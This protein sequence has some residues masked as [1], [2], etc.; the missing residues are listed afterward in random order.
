MS[1]L[2]PTRFSLC[3]C[4]SEAL[5]SLGG[6]MECS[7][8]QPGVMPAGPRQLLVHTAHMTATLGNFYGEPV[9]LQVL[10][11]R[12]TAGAYWRKI[13]LFPRRSNRIVEFGIV[14]LYLQYIPKVACDEILSRR[15]PLGAVLI[16]HNVHRR[17][18]PRWYIKAPRREVVDCFGTPAEG[19]PEEIYG[20]IG[21]IFCNGEPA[22]ELLE[23]VTE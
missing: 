3:K 19:L 8:V 5:A 21:T 22:I 7:E 16:K 18:E 1:L 11:D 20:R 10:E 2:T 4:P 14:R 9:R 12:L 6:S 17:V 15:T 23:M 13:L